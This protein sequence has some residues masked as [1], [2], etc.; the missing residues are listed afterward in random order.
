MF[1]VAYHASDFHR[2]EFPRVLGAA[3]LEIGFEYPQIGRCVPGHPAARIP[4]ACLP[5]FVQDFQLGQDRMSFPGQIAFRVAA[6]IFLLRRACFRADRF[7]FTQDMIEFMRRLGD[8]QFRFSRRVQYRFPIEQ[9]GALCMTGFASV[10]GVDRDRDTALAAQ[11]IQVTE[12]LRLERCPL[13]DFNLQQAV[14]HCL[15]V[16]CGK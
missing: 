9:D 1:E 4:A 8:Q 16:R 6:Y 3:M 5:Y 12:P 10:P 2:C 13:D 14:E 15:L 7:Q 11:C